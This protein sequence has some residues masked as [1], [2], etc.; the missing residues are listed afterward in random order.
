MWSA[1]C[2]APEWNTSDKLFVHECS[3]LAAQWRFAAPNTCPRPLQERANG[4][5]PDLWDCNCSNGNQR[6]TAESAGAGQTP[7]ASGQCLGVKE[8][9]VRDAGQLWEQQLH[10]EPA[11]TCPPSM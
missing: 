10:P 2:V 5:L 3:H 4:L 1:L 7:S 9:W 11:L 6:F 8:R